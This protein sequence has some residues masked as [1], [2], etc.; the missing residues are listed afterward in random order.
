M[1]LT[2]VANPHNRRLA[3]FNA[4]YFHNPATPYPTSPRASVRSTGR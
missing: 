4:N 3:L 1:R 2:V